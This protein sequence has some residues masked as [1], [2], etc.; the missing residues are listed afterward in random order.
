MADLQTLQEVVKQ[1]EKLSAEIT[2]LTDADPY[3]S[4]VKM[5]FETWNTGRDI[6]SENDLKI[7]IAEGRRSLIEKKT[8]ELETLLRKTHIDPT[9][10]VDLQ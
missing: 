1:A 2:K 9:A 10:E 5:S 7:V 6:L 3:Q 8:L 4:G